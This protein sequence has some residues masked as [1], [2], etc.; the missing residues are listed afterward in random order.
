MRRSIELKLALNLLYRQR[1]PVLL[2]FFFRYCFL[3]ARIVGMYYCA[4]LA[5]LP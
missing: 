1:Y 4:Q 2:I 5:H 3:N